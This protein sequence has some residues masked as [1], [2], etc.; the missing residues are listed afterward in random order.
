MPGSREPEQAPLHMTLPCRIRRKMT[1]MRHE[2]LH[3]LQPQRC[4]YSALPQE[5]SDMTVQLLQ[6]VQ[7]LQTVRDYRVYSFSHPLSCPLFSCP[8]P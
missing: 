2:E 1:W 7:I 5:G 4:I 6:P 8:D 3:A